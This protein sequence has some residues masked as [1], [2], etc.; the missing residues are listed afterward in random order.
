MN[1]FGDVA[2]AVDHA[3]TAVATATGAGGRVVFVDADLL[4]ESGVQ[5]LAK[6]SVDALGHIDIIVN[7]A[8]EWRRM[9]RP[10]TLSIHRQGVNSLHAPPP[11]PLVALGTSTPLHKQLRCCPCT[12]VPE[13][14]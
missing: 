2:G 14:P 7:N 8:G 13:M 1:G 4:L 5:H 9:A 3:I 11:H 12:W 10:R 6:A